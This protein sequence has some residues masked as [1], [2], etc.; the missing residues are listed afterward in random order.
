MWTK[1]NDDA[2]RLGTRDQTWPVEHRAPQH[3]AVL[4]KAGSIEEARLVAESSRARAAVVLLD[5]RPLPV[6]QLAIQ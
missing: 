1:L 6:T 3:Q 4:V 5:Q 2:Q